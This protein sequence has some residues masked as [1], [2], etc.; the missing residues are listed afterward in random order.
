MTLSQLSNKSRKRRYRINNGGALAGQLLKAEEGLSGNP[1]KKGTCLKVLEVKPK[2]PNSAQRKV[3]KVLLSNRQLVLAHIPGEGHSLVRHNTVL[4]RGGRVKD[5]PRVRFKLIRGKFD[6]GGVV[7][8][9]TSRSKYGV[10][11]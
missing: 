10:K 2:K 11:K 9:C 8:R 5:L 6:L 1:F 3:A 4:V 7:G